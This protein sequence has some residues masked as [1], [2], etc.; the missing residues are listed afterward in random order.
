MSFLDALTAK[1][2]LPEPPPPATGPVTA[3]ARVALRVLLA[4]I[5]VLF[6]LFLLA[7]LI[8]AQLPDW[9][10]LAGAPGRP[11]ASLAPLWFNTAL[12]LA[13]S[14]ALQAATMAARRNRAERLR[15]ALACGALFT[16]AFL[17]GQGW[18]WL[19][20]I[21]GGHFVAS[22]PAASFFYLLTGVHG[23]HL[24]GGLV[25]WGRVFARAADGAAAQRLSLEVT[26]CARYWH[27][28]FAVWLVLFAL[29][30]SPPQTLR[31]L[32]EI[33]GIR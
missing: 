9:Q 14:I 5:G 26:L 30:T 24:A 11:L 1:P 18:L 3:P 27:F 16:L 25:A 32:A 10:A 20:F 23:L 19:R 15:L 29:L 2:W 21:D 7:F 17:F 8:R 31:V 4:V 13:A 22:N 6:G 28:L 33:C 12:L